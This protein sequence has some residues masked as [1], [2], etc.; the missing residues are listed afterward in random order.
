MARIRGEQRLL[1]GF[2]VLVALTTAIGLISMVQIHALATTIRA[3][4][5]RHLPIEQA[6]LR[7]KVSNTVYVMGVR[8]HVLWRTAKYLQA[9]PIASGLTAAERSLEDFRQALDTYDSLATTQPQREWVKRLHEAADE[10]QRMGREILALAEG[11]TPDKDRVNKLLLTFENRSYKID[12]LLTESL[13]KQNLDAI[14]AHLRWTNQQHQASLIIL[15]LSVSCSIV[16]GVAIARFVYRS[17][18]QERQMRERM[19]QRMINLEEEERKNLSRQI[20]DQLSQDLSALKIYLG[21]IDQGLPPELTELK[22]RL[23]KSK[24]ILGNL[25][26]RGHNIS[27]LLRPSELDELGLVESI[28]VL[29]AE[30]R[31]ITGCHYRFQRPTTQLQLPSAH[32][33]ALYRIVQETLTNIA[34][35]AS[36]TRVE[37]AL[38]QANG[39]VRLTITDDGQG[40]ES[41]E[42]FNRPR[43]RK[44]DVM[45][46]GLLGLRER[47]ELLGG[48]LRIRTA[49]G[50]GTVITAEL[51]V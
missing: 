51:A 20:H 15:I 41:G 9:V 2:G 3:F 5:Q 7:M 34:K 25:V 1:V 6:I 14:D 43:R 31:E 11:E 8:N 48:R 40:F 42:V 28:A 16:L 46:L 35:H 29:V 30:H 26:E 33:L 50:K 19:A 32:S 18:T 37:I 49:P 23:E 36:A 22:D 24:K 38:Q 45:R 47:M 17:L 13:S 21:L 12:E 10:L 39:A 44:N 4:G 27:E